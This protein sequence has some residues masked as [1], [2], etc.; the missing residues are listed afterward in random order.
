[1]L[2]GGPDICS[3]N[4]SICS[5]I[6]YMLSIATQLLGHTRSAVLGTLLLRPEVSLHVRELARIAGVSAGSLHRELRMLA[7]LGL[8]V[9]Q[10]V[11]RQVHYRA[12]EA[13]PVF[14]ELAGLLRKTSG[15]ADVLRE[16]L[17]PLGS[18]ASMAFVYGSVAAGTESASSDVDVMV[19]GSA[20]FAD[21]VRAL[22]GAQTVLQREVNPTVLRAREFEQRFAEGDGFA[23]SVAKGQRL[24]LIGGEDD[25]AE[26]VADRKAEGTRGHARRGAAAARGH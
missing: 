18:K 1:V 4:G 21:V 14:A 15:L 24:W 20:S 8:L 6:S 3:Q 16:T 10:E 22:S 11:G 23:R 7:E 13:S 5:K 12:N 9:R 2:R 26:L 19:L 17:T 25:F